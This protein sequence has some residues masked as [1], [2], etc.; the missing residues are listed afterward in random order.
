MIRTPRILM[1]TGA[2]HP[3]ISSSGVQC[4]DVARLLA[5]QTDVRV[6][7]TAVDRRLPRMDVVDGV[8]VRRI[9]VDVTSRVSKLVATL[10][11]LLALTRLVRWADV[12]HLHGFST[13]NLIVTAMAKLFGRSL[14][15][16]LH[17][18]DHDEAP[19]IRRHGRMAW[20]AFTHV[21]HYLSVS[22]RLIDA[23]LAEGLAPERIRLV[24]NGIDLQRFRPAS[25]HE[26]VDL[27]LRLGLPL[28]PPVIVFVGFFSHDKQ[29]SVAFDAW[30]ILAETHGVD[31]TLVFVGATKS[32]Y[33]EV[34]ED[35]AAAMRDDAAKA[36]RGERLRFAGVTPDVQDY[37]RAANVFVLPSRREGLPVAL[38]EAMAC[39]LPCIASRL[40]RVTDTIISDGVDGVL[41]PVGDARA[42]A[43]A[44]AKVIQNSTCAAALGSAAR[45]TVERRFQNRD[46]AVEWLS[47]YHH[48]LVAAR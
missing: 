35:L 38:L 14:V 29:P 2:Y 39:G 33:F 27:R 37:F 26:R 31:A 36:G 47:A 4:R 13:K 6:L 7:T 23:Y 8:D 48:V 10:H 28:Q 17:T 34:D 40:P 45:A 21:D 24:P 44:L 42:F 46:V 15:L 32:A 1:V 16:S 22:P 41:V 12:I 20:W 9:Y 5:G 25:A 30:T 19:A 18:A 43:G 11:M 3:E